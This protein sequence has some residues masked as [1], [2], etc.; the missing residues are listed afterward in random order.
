MDDAVGRAFSVWA[1]GTEGLEISTMGVLTLSSD[2]LVFVGPP[3][4]E[5]DKASDLEI[6]IGEGATATVA[7]NVGQPEATGFMVTV[8]WDGKSLRFL[9]LSEEDATAIAKHVGIEAA[10]G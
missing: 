1:I 4:L 10:P 7:P 5:S 9:N 3:L 6:P 2:H 8:I